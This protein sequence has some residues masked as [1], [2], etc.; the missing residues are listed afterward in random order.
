M[1]GGQPNASSMG[2]AWDPETRSKRPHRISWHLKSLPEEMKAF[3]RET[4]R[5]I[6]RLLALIGH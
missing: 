6:P 1:P 4:V 2:G 3:D 5:N